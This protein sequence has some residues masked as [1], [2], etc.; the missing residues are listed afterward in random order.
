[1]VEG[2]QVRIDIASIIT[3][4]CQHMHGYSHKHNIHLSLHSY[5]HEADN[6]L[7]NWNVHMLID[8]L[9]CISSPS[10]VS[11]NRHN[12]DWQ[13]SSFLWMLFLGFDFCG[14]KHTKALHHLMLSWCKVTFIFVA[15]DFY[16]KVYIVLLL[17]SNFIYHFYRISSNV[18]SLWRVVNM[19]NTS[20]KTYFALPFHPCPPMDERHHLIEEH[21]NF[22]AISR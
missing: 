18:W 22:Y 15:T 5:T 9:Y 4:H 6:P 2:P 3:M 10:R 21:L 13:Y 14:M 17:C 7:H 16:R 8:G 11:E 1:M 19:A 20:G 12:N